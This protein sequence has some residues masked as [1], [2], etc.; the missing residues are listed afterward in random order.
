MKRRIALLL[1]VSLVMMMFAG[2]ASGGTSEAEPS[3]VATEGTEE[4]TFLG[5]EEETYYMIVM[6]SGVEYWPPVYETFKQAGDLLG[7][8]TVFTG[9]PEY[10]VNKE[11]AVFEQVLAKKP[12]GIFVHPMN[13]DAFIE[14]INRAVEMGIPVVT[15]AADSP[16]SNRQAYITSDNFKEGAMAADVIAEDMGYKGEVAV[17]EN[18]GQ[19][20]H[21]RRIKAFIDR[22]ESEYPD[23]EVVAR[24]ATNQDP[25]KAYQAVL[26][27]AQAHPDLGAV[28]MPEASSGMGAAQAASEL[29]T[30]IRVMCTD[31]NA[32]VLDMIKA[33][34]MWG[35]INPN[36]GM[37]GYFGMLALF[38]AAHADRI[39]PMTDYL[40]TGKNPIDIPVIDNGLSVVTKENAEYFY[41]DKYLERTGSKGIEE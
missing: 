34:E 3:T 31:V 17:L 2:C 23:M 19:D 28:F 32:S 40:V 9:T 35:A 15:F 26:T 12:A 4:E 7:V 37:Q 41:L 8:K 20:N 14:P 22:I 16:K 39:D 11:L 13:A 36:Q 29:G 5:S 21:D 38:S 25:N 30:G 27:M 1:I 10:D 18:P 6:V 33:G 24:A